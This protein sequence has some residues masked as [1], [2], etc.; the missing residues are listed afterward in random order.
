M[1]DPS[2]QTITKTINELIHL[3]KAGQL[4]LEPGFQ[5]DS[6]WNLKDRQ[7]LI[8]SIV[9][10]YPLPAIFLYERTEGHHVKYDVIDGKQRIESILRFTGDL[11]GHG[12]AMYEAS[13]LL[14]GIEEPETVTWKLLK[15]R[16]HGHRISTY[17]LQVVEV[18]GDLHDIINLFVRINSTGKALSAQEK[19]SAKYYQSVF[20]KRAVKLAER[21]KKKLKSHKVLG[22]SH[23]ARRKHIELMCELM[24]AAHQ[25]GPSNKKS[26]IDRIMKA[27]ITQKQA[28]NAAKATNAAMKRVWQLLPDIK[29]T[30]FAKLADFYTLVVLLQGFARE[31]LALANKRSLRLAG[32]IL[33]LFGTGVDRLI[34]KQKKLEGSKPADA[35][36]REYLFTVKE[37]TDAL[38]NRQ[39][40]ARI[41][42]SLI[43]PLFEVKDAKR[44]FT[45]EQRRI[46]WNTTE[47]RRCKVCKKALTWDDFQMD[48]VIAHSKGGK[49]DLKNAALLCATHNAKKGNR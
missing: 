41:L 18:R 37:G 48:H 1:T 42:D 16:G 38:S 8:D 47:A 30:R 31:G 39:A 44:I 10:G 12:N 23:F 2:Y 49:T 40:R 21:S 14:P 13:V 36:Y 33:R 15:K 22:A 32:D 7:G 45:P 24:L 17:K 20:L 19:R 34:D 29:S 27:D 43:R 6:V 46:L 3:K 26:A 9:R 11:H 5:R 4:N 28:E 25:G 35:L